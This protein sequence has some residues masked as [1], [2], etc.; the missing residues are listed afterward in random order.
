M[1]SVP[2][3][4]SIAVQENINEHIVLSNMAEKWDF[5]RFLSICHNRQLY[6][7]TS[8]MRNLFLSKNRIEETKDKDKYSQHESMKNI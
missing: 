1:R 8:C 6:T 2:D 7:I 3:N 4:S 5:V